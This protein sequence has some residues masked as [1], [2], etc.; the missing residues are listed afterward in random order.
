MYRTVKHTDD[1]LVHRG[2]RS[3]V[4]TVGYMSFREAHLRNTLV[5]DCP[6]RTQS[7]TRLYFHFEEV[8]KFSSGTRGRCIIC[9]LGMEMTG[10]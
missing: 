5:F 1:I 7:V 10:M 9:G 4:K 2:R 3:G 8:H 6:V